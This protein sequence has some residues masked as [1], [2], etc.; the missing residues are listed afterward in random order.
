MSWSPRRLAL[1]LTA[2]LTAGMACGDKN[3]AT[4]GAPGSAP[5][6]AATQ[7]GAAAEGAAA[8]AEVVFTYSPVGKRDPF[9]SYLVEIAELSAQ[10]LPN[11]K[12][13]D[14]EHFEMGQYRLTGLVTGTSRPKAMVE[15]PQG[16]GHVLHVGSR[17][18]R[19]GGRVS[20]IANAGVTVTE[21]TLDPTGKKVRLSIFM[22]LP[23]PEMDNLAQDN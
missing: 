2:G 13:E 14:T 9:R 6:A 20:T 4:D 11:R 5:P 17:L 10:Q 23:K 1:A 12:I 19:N 22:K 16:H 3:T 15:D 21:E 18:G 8:P 7:A